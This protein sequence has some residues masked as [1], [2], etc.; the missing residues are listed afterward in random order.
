M[1]RRI[2][3]DFNVFERFLSQ[4]NL[5]SYTA[6]PRQVEACK[7][8]H[9]K[10]F[11]LLVFNAEFKVQ[12]NYPNSVAF[13]DEMASDL[14][15]SLFCVVQGLYKPAKLQLRCCMENFL[16]SLI[17][18]NEPAIIHEKSV[19]AVFDAAKNDS[20]FHTLI[21]QACI[22][23]LHNDYSTL[24][25]TVHGDPKIM[26]PVSALSMLPQYNQGSH[27]EI[28][29]IYIRTVEQCLGVLYLNFPIVVDQMHPDNKKDFL[30]CLSKTT[31]GNVVNT[32]Y[33]L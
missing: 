12:G 32:L 29:S 16:K 7:G 25:R 26:K 24:C 33:G 30:D 15:L 2:S 21:G 13:L 14:L 20:H 10:L 17:M 8:M 23:T 22:D 18:I 1:S 6:V 9:K 5:T 11:G 31:K 3:E 19:Y 4:Y 28:S 27:Q